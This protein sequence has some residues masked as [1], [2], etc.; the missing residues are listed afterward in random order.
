MS[1]FISSA[2]TNITVTG[3]ASYTINDI[4]FINTVITANGIVA[5]NNN[6]LY[7]NVPKL[8][9]K[10]EVGWFNTESDHSATE[11]DHSATAAATVK[12]NTDDT[13]TITVNS[14]TFGAATAAGQEYVVEGWVKLA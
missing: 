4:L 13:G 6:V 3:D 12:S 11:S 9:N 10:A 5:A 7:I 1:K 2:D 14:I 8:G